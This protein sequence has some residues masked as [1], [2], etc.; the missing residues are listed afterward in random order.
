MQKTLNDFVLLVLLAIATVLGVGI[1]SG[2][3]VVL[4]NREYGDYVVI[5]GLTNEM[6]YGT[7]STGKQV[8][9]NSKEHVVVGQVYDVLRV[10]KSGLYD[11]VEVK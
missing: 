11:V 4:K 9:V 8:L 7:T 10:D 2:E 5:T 1:V 3:L 6:V